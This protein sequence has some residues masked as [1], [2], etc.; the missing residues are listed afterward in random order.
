[1]Y[2]SV[3]GSLNWVWYLLTV[4]FH[5]DIQVFMWRTHLDSAACLSMRALR[6]SF[7]CW[8]FFRLSSNFTFLS[9][10][11]EK[12]KEELSIY[13][14]FCSIACF[15]AQ[16]ICSSATVLTSLSSS[17]SFFSCWWSCLFLISRTTLRLC[18]SCSRYRVC[19][20]FCKDECKDGQGLGKSSIMSA[21]SFIQII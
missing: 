8:T 1:M 19:V 12:K 2:E 20:S 17:I 14:S 5:H 15:V 21:A 16:Q 6:S 9:F 7:S 11:I 18:S 13:H 3:T 10:W 4:V